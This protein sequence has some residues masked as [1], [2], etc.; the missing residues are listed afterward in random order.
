[1]DYQKHLAKSN[2]R[3]ICG[4]SSIEF[5]EV[6]GL[7]V[8]LNNFDFKVKADQDLKPEDISSLQKFVTLS[9]KRGVTT[10]DNE[11]F[12]WL[13]TKAPNQAERRLIG[14]AILDDRHRTV[15]YYEISGMYPSKI[16]YV[17]LDPQSNKIAIER[18][19]LSVAKSDS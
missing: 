3:V 17:T 11:F 13:N 19:E 6:S 2:F 8:K 10:S 12:K 4:E 15:G 9:L 16:D 5:A 1:M 14:I 7:Q 18:V